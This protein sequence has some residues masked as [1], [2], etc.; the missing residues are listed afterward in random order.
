MDSARCNP[1]PY[2]SHEDTGIRQQSLSR[3]LRHARS[4]PVVAVRRRLQAHIP[5]GGH[6]HANWGDENQ[7]KV[8]LNALLWVAKAEVPKN[9]VA[10]KVTPE[11]L[12]A[13]LDPKPAKK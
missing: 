12:A 11:Q 7:R 4:I 8:V 6:T 10:S 2:R 13:N 1:V 5:V 9:G 3:W